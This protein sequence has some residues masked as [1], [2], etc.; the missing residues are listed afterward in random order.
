MIFLHEIPQP[1][2]ETL[3]LT[4]VGNLY[5]QITSEMYLNDPVMLN[6]WQHNHFCGSEISSYIRFCH[7]KD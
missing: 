5:Q 2:P 7:Y 4:A 6:R 3:Q 1:E